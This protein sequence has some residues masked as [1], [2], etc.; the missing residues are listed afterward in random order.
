MKVM[1]VSIVILLVLAGVWYF[2]FRNPSVP[3]A[4]PSAPSTVSAAQTQQ[5][6]DASAASLPPAPP[7]IPTDVP[8]STPPPVILGQ[9]VLMQDP[10]FSWVQAAA[11]SGV[12]AVVSAATGIRTNFTAHG[13][14][15]QA[16]MSASTSASSSAP[17]RAYYAA[18]YKT[19]LTASGGTYDKT[20]SAANGK[21]N[22]GGYTFGSSAPA[23][24]PGAVWGYLLKGGIYEQV[25]ASDYVKDTVRE[26]SLSYYP[27]QAD[28]SPCKATARVPC[29]DITY[30]VFWS[31][32]FAIG[33]IL[34]G[35]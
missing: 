10:A 22:V 28:G 7:I 26:L 20:V 25:V 6:G 15:W 31:D 29:P 11:T 14:M 5:A 24:A 2:V 27:S 33:D 34:K 23:S 18:F 9:Q 12:I 19:Y 32:L 13:T 30:T 35:S 17:F 16:T 21:V 8:A 3:P 1:V 4:A